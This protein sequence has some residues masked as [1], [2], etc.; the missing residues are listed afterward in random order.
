VSFALPETSVR[1]IFVL[2]TLLVIK[3]LRFDETF[4]RKITFSSGG[5]VLWI[6]LMGLGSFGAYAQSPL[7]TDWTEF[8]IN[9]V[10]KAELALQRQ[11][12]NRSM[13][14]GLKAVF[15]V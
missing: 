7:F 3:S 10:S 8:T 15:V 9:T 6:F 1:Q 4:R 5:R 2:K 12:A 13:F 11:L 14:E